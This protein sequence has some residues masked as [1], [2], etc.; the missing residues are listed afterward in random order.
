MM[1]LSLYTNESYNVILAV[2]I[3]DNELPTNNYVDP[4][5]HFGH[6]EPSP[7]YS[8]LLQLFP[9]IQVLTSMQNERDTAVEKSF[10]ILQDE[11]DQ[12]SV[13][14]HRIAIK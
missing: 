13:N 8:E 7:H 5:S 3:L 10:G 4:I 6:F 12:Y 9:L 14:I 11:I 1:A 2:W